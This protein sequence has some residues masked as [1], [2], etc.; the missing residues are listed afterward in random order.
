MSCTKEGKTIKSV[1]ACPFTRDLQQQIGEVQ[2]VNRY[3]NLLLEGCYD[4]QIAKIM[5]LICIAGL[6]VKV[7]VHPTLNLCKDVVT[8][9]DF[10]WESVED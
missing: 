1:S 3:G 8:R 6:Q 4:S 10:T 9:E 7:E 5:L 2:S